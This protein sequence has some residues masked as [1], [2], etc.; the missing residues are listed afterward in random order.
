MHTGASV[1][2]ARSFASRSRDTLSARAGAAGV[3]VARRSSSVHFFLIWNGVLPS[4][5]AATSR[6][7]HAGK[8]AATGPIDAS[9]G[10]GLWRAGWGGASLGGHS[11]HA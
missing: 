7:P 11:D 9:S 8:H 2:R 6:S 10:G 3:L 1:R 5:F 4:P